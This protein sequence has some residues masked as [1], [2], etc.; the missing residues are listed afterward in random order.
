M[1]TIK[2]AC[3]ARTMSI[4]PWGRAKPQ[5][6]LPDRLG[7]RKDGGAASR[8]RHRFG[9]REP[10]PAEAGFGGFFC[11]FVGREGT[12]SLRPSA[13]RGPLSFAS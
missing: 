7:Q 11:N 13:F 6:A 5:T 12:V 4:S 10:A 8:R 1:K 3:A 2:K 9:S